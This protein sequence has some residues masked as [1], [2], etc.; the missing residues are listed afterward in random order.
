MLRNAAR[1]SQAVQFRVEQVAVQGPY[2][3]GEIVDALRRLDARIPSVDVIVIA[4]GGGSHRGP[5]AVLR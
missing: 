5:A 3:V 1:R 2:A 4:R